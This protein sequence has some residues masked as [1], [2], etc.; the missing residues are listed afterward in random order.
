MGLE[1]LR[2]EDVGLEDVGPGDVRL[3]DV[4]LGTRGLGDS[5]TR[6]QPWRPF[7]VNNCFLLDPCLTLA[8][9]NKKENT[10]TYQESPLRLPSMFK[11]PCVETILYPEFLPSKRQTSSHV[12][13]SPRPTSP[14]P[15]ET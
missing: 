7:L 8:K 15:T 1:D 14:S 11:T 12:L 4:R 13:E 3:G 6:G 5:G 10:V 2:L 9:K